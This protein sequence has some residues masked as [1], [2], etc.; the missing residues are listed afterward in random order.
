MQS[1]LG[2][3]FD[4]KRLKRAVDGSFKLQV[5]YVGN[6]LTTRF[7]I[8]VIP[9]TYYEHD[10]AELFH[11]VMEFTALELRELLLA[12]IYDPKSGRTLR[13]V[14]LGVK[15][16][17]PYLQKCGR[18]VRA[19]NTGVKRG[20][21]NTAPKGICHLCLAGTHNV[22]AEEIA[23]DSPAWVQ[24]Q[25]VKLPW[26]KTPVMVQHLPHNLDDPSTYFAPDVWHTVHLG[27]GKA[28]VASVVQA[29]L[30]QI[31][32]SNLDAKWE[33]L[34]SSYRRCCKAKQRQPHVVKITAYLMSYGEKAGAQGSW[35]K[36]ALTTN[37]MLWI[38]VLLE[39]IPLDDAGLVSKCKDAATKMND[40]FKHLYQ[41]SAFLDYNECM[42]VSDLLAGFLKIYATLA[43]A[44]FRQSKPHL[45]RCI[46]NCI[47]YTMSATNFAQMLPKLASA[48][49]Q[50]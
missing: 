3:G 2:F 12:G 6:S 9:K 5:N 13:V 44:Y 32:E 23:T 38:P 15:G 11:G 30:P 25:G 48:F 20:K 33:F 16:D 18:L 40:I 21:E 34:T 49:P 50:C 1:A 31:E 24:T 36:G 35:S 45:F 26:E 28:C 14:L 19:F 7:V 41:A 43:M 22:P 10:N 42:Y 39:E 8:S 27:I 46:Q 37:L 47:F 4:Q 29:C 17:W